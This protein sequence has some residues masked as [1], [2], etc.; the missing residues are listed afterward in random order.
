MP[1]RV[2]LQ[3]KRVIRCKRDLELNKPNI[4]AQHKPLP[5]EGDSSMK[6]YRGKWWVKDSSA[7]HFVP[8]LLLTR[9]PSA[10]ELL[11]LPNLPNISPTK[12]SR[13][14]SYSG[15]RLE[16]TLS[17]PR[18]TAMTVSIQAVKSFDTDHID[19]KEPTFTPF[20]CATVPLSAM[21]E[22][23]DAPTVTVSLAAYEDELLREVE[24]D[25]DDETVISKIFE[26]QIS[27]KK[28][29]STAESTWLTASLHNTCRVSI[30]LQPLQLDEYQSSILK[31]QQQ[32]MQEESITGQNKLVCTLSLRLILNIESMSKS[33]GESSTV[34]L[35]IAIPIEW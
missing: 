15:C 12:V 27:D 17:N 26:T 34:D 29:I 4:L 3:T 8:S 7:I 23:T 20:H 31:P 5:L 25:E 10:Q 35:M 33:P 21:G 6:V 19:T 2:G 14:I 30:P 11:N 1:N 22:S 28:E 24:D 16:F 32:G 18:D 13:S 9:L